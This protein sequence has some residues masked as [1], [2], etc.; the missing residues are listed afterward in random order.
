MNGF[1]PVNSQRT[2][3]SLQVVGPHVARPRLHARPAI[4]P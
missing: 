3:I 4:K 1:V 2:G